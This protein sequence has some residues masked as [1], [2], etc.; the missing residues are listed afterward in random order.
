VEHCG[1]FEVKGRDHEVYKESK[2][3]VG[4]LYQAEL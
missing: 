3:V 4:G 1:R 2:Y